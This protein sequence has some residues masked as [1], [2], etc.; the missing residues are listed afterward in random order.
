[1]RNYKIIMV[2]M[3]PEA[4]LKCF[5]KKLWLALVVDKSTDHDKPHFDLCFYHN[6]N[7][8]NMFVF[9]QSPDWKRHFATHWREQRGINSYWQRQ[10][11]QSDCEITS[12][13]GKILIRIMVNFLSLMFF[14]TELCSNIFLNLL[15]SE[16]P[17]VD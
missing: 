12:N 11:S 13:W 14:G 5:G 10:I 1:M 4:I 16:K 2:E 17:D 9:F 6:I 8:E 3:Y 7:V 15:T